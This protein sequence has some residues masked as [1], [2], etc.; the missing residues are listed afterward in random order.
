M[1]AA[2][3]TGSGGIKNARYIRHKDMRGKNNDQV[4]V[5]PRAKTGR[6]DLAKSRP[7]SRGGGSGCDVG[8]ATR[9]IGATTTET[10][11]Q[12]ETTTATGSATATAS[13]TTGCPV[14]DFSGQ[15]FAGVKIAVRNAPR[16]PPS[17][18]LKTRYSQLVDDYEST[19]DVNLTPVTISLGTAPASSPSTTPIGENRISTAIAITIGLA[20]VAS[21]ALLAAAFFFWMA[22]RRRRRS[23]R[24]SSRKAKS[25]IS[26]PLVP[27]ETLAHHSASP[28]SLALP[29]PVAKVDRAP[30]SAAT[31]MAAA[32]PAHAVRPFGS[33]SGLKLKD[34]QGGGSPWWRSY[35]SLDRET[36]GVNI[37]MNEVKAP[38]Q[39]WSIPPPM[40]MD[41][42]LHPSINGSASSI[43]SANSTSKSHRGHVRGR[44]TPLLA[45]NP[46]VN[47]QVSILPIMAIQPPLRSVRP[48]ATMSSASSIQI[49]E[50]DSRT[51]TSSPKSPRELSIPGTVMG[52]KGPG[53]PPSRALPS[54]PQ[55]RCINPS[56]PPAKSHIN[57]LHPK[58]NGVAVGGP[59]HLG[60]TIDKP[61]YQVWC[62]ASRWQPPKQSTPGEQTF[63]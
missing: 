23:G 42:K 32:A 51:L 9:L 31:I 3:I 13:V 30:T 2:G 1:A 22:C 59:S 48:G 19:L 18:S 14:T 40:L 57:T 34:V 11:T 15:G 47:W 45:S 52:L 7:G 4:S 44:H 10:D 56:S 50:H 55:N 6:H 58:E 28:T 33:P 16:H 5:D 20:T 61:Y 63:F 35:S 49:T 36:T 53:P 17:T 26:S 46:A 27:L 21:L 54:P 8:E 24:L 41:R 43:P 37:G 29:A 60:I 62:D 25:E 12:S 39:H 38:D